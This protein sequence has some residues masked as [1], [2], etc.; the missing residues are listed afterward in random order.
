[1]RDVKD[2]SVARTTRAVQ[3]AE[4]AVS[5]LIDPLPHHATVA[6]LGLGLTGRAACAMLLA[7]GKKVIASDTRTAINGLAALPHHPS[8]TCHL[9]KID[10]GDATIAVVSPGLNPTWPEHRNDPRLAALFTP[11]APTLRSEID[12]AA[13]S[14]RAPIV[15]I[16]GTDGKSTTAALTHHLLQSLGA[17]TLLGGNS[18]SP[19][20]ERAL[21]LSSVEVAVVEV[22][23]FQLWDGHRFAPD[24]RLLTNI[25]PDHLDHYDSADDY[26]R[27][28]LH[29]L[30]HVSDATRVIL[31][32]DD[33][34]LV[35]ATPA[36]QERGA[37]VTGVA[38]TRPREA[39]DQ[40]AFVEHEQCVVETPR[41]VIRIPVQSLRLPG[42]H[43]QRNALMAIAAAMQVL[44]YGADTPTTDA[45]TNRLQQGL[46]TF[47]GLA[48]R[49]EWIRER[50][51]VD[52]FNDSKATN[53]HAA[54][55]GIR[56]I[57]RP[58][59]A[60]VGGVDKGLD[61]A[62]LVEALQQNARHTVVIGEL[63]DRLYR[64]LRAAQIPASC[65]ETLDE[66]VEEASRR[67]TPGDCVLLSPAASS[68]DMF[69]GFEARGD[70][71]RALVHALEP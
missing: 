51:G 62:P 11:A 48:H 60:I 38:N 4:L 39:W 67:A 53:V 49:I 32:A 36:L 44:P 45:L 3:H 34:R 57:Q 27:A 41:G 5:S 17:R 71:F 52:Y 70:A 24:V 43:N 21:A 30:D 40:I 65:A 42:A 9:G 59:V 6:V 2:Q 50:R 63:R 58:L 1:L 37:S 33:P 31:F 66:A 15:A 7:L 68:F 19:L 26:V 47:T 16:G 10:L 55:I 12:V 22:S 61:V 35:R 64:D 69:S 18:W 28:K 54:I 29:L 8:L 25:A 56:A 20:S 13:L 46:G 14:L 23:A